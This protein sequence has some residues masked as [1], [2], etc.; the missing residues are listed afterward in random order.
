MTGEEISLVI[1]SQRD[2]DL[3]VTGDNKGGNVITCRAGGKLISAIT[4]TDMRHVWNVGM[5]D[6]LQAYN[7]SNHLYLT[8][9]CQSGECVQ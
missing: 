1:K 3:C 7:L 6:T 2:D 4:W 9:C 8:G 5:M